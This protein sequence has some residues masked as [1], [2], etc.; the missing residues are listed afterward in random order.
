M[1]LFSQSSDRCH[2]EILCPQG[3]CVGCAHKKLWCLDTQCYPYCQNCSGS[4]PANS[5][6]TSPVADTQPYDIGIPVPHPNSVTVSDALWAIFI[7]LLA[8]IIIG[9]LIYYIIIK[10]R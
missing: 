3:N 9:F 6:L 8:T 7:I 5:I 10:F 4:T 2:D 1:A